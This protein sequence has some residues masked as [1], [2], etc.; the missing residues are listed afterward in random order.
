MAI[1]PGFRDY[2]ADQMSRVLPVKIRSM[3]GGAGIYSEGVIFG[4]IS[5][6]RVYLKVDESN[7][8]DFERLG[9]KPFR[10]FGEARGA[11]SYYELPADRLECPDELRPW[12]LKALAAGRA[13]P[14]RGVRKRPPG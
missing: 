8:P 1:D 14:T 6:D 12:I 9:M 2:V 3:F 13:A 10:P 4:L 7:R 5:E 11:M